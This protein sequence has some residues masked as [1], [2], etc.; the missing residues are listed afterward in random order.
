[1]LLRFKPPLPHTG[2]SG[3]DP[4][5]PACGRSA[6]LPQQRR[7]AATSRVSVRSSD[8]K[9]TPPAHTK[10]TLAG[11]PFPERYE[12]QATG[13]PQPPYPCCIQT[14][15]EYSTR[16]FMPTAP[17]SSQQPL[18][19]SEAKLIEFQADFPPSH[20]DRT[21]L[22]SLL[23]HGSKSLKPPPFPAPAHVTIRGQAVYTGSTVSSHRLR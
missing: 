4:V 15:S 21:Q 8:F 6:G 20:A 17:S 19:S 22:L 9:P 23:P 5:P 18:N 11:N 14:T 3:Q 7:D 2:T 10:A 12:F 16:R 13:P 1:M